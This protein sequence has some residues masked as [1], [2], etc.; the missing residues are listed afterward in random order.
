MKNSLVLFICLSIV[1]LTISCNNS[2]GESNTDNL[3]SKMS[4]SNHSTG[5]D[6]MIS[7]FADLGSNNSSSS[8]S[9]KSNSEVITVEVGT[10]KELFS[11]IASNRIIKLKAGIYR[12]DEL[13]T[14]TAKN[15]YASIRST[16]EEFGDEFIIHDIQNLSIIGLGNKQV[17][18]FTKFVNANVLSFENSN[19]IRLSNLRIGH[20]PDLG[21]CYGGVLFFKDSSS[22]TIEKCNLFGCGVNGLEART[23]KNLIFKD[24]TIEECSMLIMS[25]SNC[26]TI[27][28]QGSNFINNRGGA[29]INITGCT[30]VLFDKCNIADNHGVTD[31]GV[32]F[33]VDCGYSP[34]VSEFDWNNVI[35]QILI[36]NSDI[37]GNS[38]VAPDIARTADVSKNAL[39]FENVTFEG[40]SF[41]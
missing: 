18:I 32:L 37:K 19:N 34:Y 38:T 31:I 16:G 7:E 14:I 4:E 27:H 29:L 35:S 21:G 3:N 13:A 40:N 36:K 6:A 11:A 30:D 8:E 25:V 15:Q 1:L 9:V 23:V 33:T 10:V 17:E 2:Q 22:I 24:S 41:D 28:F 12:L 5:K 39:T 20:S 26:E